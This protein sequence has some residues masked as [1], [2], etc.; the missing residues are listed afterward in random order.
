MQFRSARSRA[1]RDSAVQ[2][3]QKSAECS[4]VPFRRSRKVQFRSSASQR[5]ERQKS[6]QQSSEEQEVQSAVQ[7][8]SEKEEIKCSSAALSSS[9]GITRASS[10]CTMT[11]LRTFLKAS[12]AGH[13]SSGKL[14]SDSRGLYCW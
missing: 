12:R 6:D 8:S 9:K 13:N 7:C 2:K 11:Y 10:L 14:F 4:P 1:V 3:F 5:N